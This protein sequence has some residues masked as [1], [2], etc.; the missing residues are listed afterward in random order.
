MRI[1]T[2]SENITI[3]QCE[4]GGY[5]LQGEWPKEARISCYMFDAPFIR[6]DKNGLIHV[7]LYNGHAVYA[8]TSIRETLLL[9]TLQRGC[10]T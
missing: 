9:A 6:F 2:M 3:R 5:Y 8:I 10:R 7:E 1:E 4:M